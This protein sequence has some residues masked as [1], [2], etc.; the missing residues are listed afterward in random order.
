V[1]LNRAV[2]VSMAHGPL[3]ALR[4]VDDLGNDPR[5]RDYHLL[6]SVRGDLLEKLG[7]WDEAHV[8]FS[9]AAALTNNAQE[10]RLLQSRMAACGTPAVRLH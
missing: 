3:E 4:I 10:Q 7:R 5:L 9:R 8:E 1:A 2:A 6:P